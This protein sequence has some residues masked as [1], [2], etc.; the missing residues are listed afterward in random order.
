L[1]RRA[2][3]GRDHIARRWR[4]TSVLYLNVSAAHV[5]HRSGD[6]AGGGEPRLHRLRRAFARITLPLIMPGLFAGGTIV[7]IWSFHGIGDAA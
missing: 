2:Y 3:F 7:F 1:A 5:E 4:F 6:G